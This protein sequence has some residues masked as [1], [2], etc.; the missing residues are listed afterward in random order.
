MRV[1]EAE[2]QPLDGIGGDLSGHW[3]LPARSGPW[4]NRLKAAV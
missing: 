1:R 2:I 3:L 4:S